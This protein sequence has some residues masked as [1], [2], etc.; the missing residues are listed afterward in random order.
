[1]GWP[2]GTPSHGRRPDL[3]RITDVLVEGPLHCRDGTFF[4]RVGAAKA[5]GDD[6]FTP[7]EVEGFFEGVIA[8]YGV[9][10]VDSLMNAMGLVRRYFEHR[11]GLDDEPLPR[12]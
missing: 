10:P 5:D 8:V 1:M 3:T 12:L 6:H 9:G 2:P 7:L 11:N 4:I